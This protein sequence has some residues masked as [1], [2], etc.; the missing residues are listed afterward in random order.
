MSFPLSVHAFGALS[1]E[2]GHLYREMER[3]GMMLVKIHLPTKNFRLSGLSGHFA[4]QRNLEGYLIHFQPI[5]SREPMLG[6]PGARDPV[7]DNFA[8]P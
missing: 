4:E 6:L 5:C 7:T 1:K 8:G 3:P 2:W